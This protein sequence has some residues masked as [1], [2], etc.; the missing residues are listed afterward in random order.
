MKNIFTIIVMFAA[1]TF[2]A[3]TDKEYFR[4]YKKDS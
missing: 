4:P 3:Q 2:N 1:I